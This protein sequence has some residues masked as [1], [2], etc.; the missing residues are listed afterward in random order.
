MPERTEQRTSGRAI[1]G[2]AYIVSTDS[3]TITTRRQLHLGYVPQEDL[4]PPGQTVQQVMLD[5]LQDE[6][7]EEH[8]RLTRIAIWP[9]G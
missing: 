7:L 1:A 9:S 2:D 8:E 4:F 6:H 5:A 3:G